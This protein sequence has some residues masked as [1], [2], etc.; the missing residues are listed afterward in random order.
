[1]LG[2]GNLAAP[3]STLVSVIAT[4]P[5]YVDFDVPERELAHLRKLSQD[6]ATPRFGLSGDRDFPLE[7]KVEFVDN[8]VDPSNGTVR[9]RASVPN[10]QWNILPGMFVRVQMPIG[11]PHEELLL[12]EIAVRHTN[13]GE[14]FIL[15]A[16]RDGVVEWRPVKIAPQPRDG[17]RVVSS[18]LKPDDR[19]IIDGRLPPAG[20]PI[21]VREAGPEK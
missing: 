12:P 6:G 4:D 14:T 21:R 20:A 15:V 1:M 17:Q 7:G 2:V 10:A 9:V 11:E 5:I 8:H 18:G 3:T 19:V 13:K 16:G